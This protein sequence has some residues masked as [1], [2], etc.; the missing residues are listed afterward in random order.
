MVCETKIRITMIRVQLQTL[1]DNLA[2]TWVAK[3]SVIE[4]SKLERIFIASCG[5]IRPSEMRSSRASVRATPMLDLLYS[6]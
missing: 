5:A 6:S 2:F 4:R 1:K 3:I